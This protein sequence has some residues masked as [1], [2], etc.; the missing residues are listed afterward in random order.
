MNECFRLN[1][2]FEADFQFF[3]LRTHQDVEIDLIV[4]K[5]GGKY[6]L[7]REKKARRTPEGVEIL[8]WFE[9]LMSLFK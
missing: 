5:P 2:Y 6:I 3:Y 9:G 1:D 4:R 8:P 7:C